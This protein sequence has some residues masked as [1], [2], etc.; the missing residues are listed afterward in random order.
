MVN[1][2]GDA[3]GCGIV[4]HMC[5]EQLAIPPVLDAGDNLAHSDVRHS[6]Q[7]VVSSQPPSYD[8]SDV[9]PPSSKRPYDVTNS[10]SHREDTIHTAL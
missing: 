8:G 5:R 10:N 9:T 3:F 4:S 6:K 1:V 7:S 2:E